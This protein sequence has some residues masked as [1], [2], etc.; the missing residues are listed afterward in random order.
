MVKNKAG[1]KE[2]EITEA[3]KFIKLMKKSAPSENQILR[4]FLD[5]KERILHE[6]L[7]NCCSDKFNDIKESA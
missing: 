6:D 7:F 4:E 3:L 5:E 2:M 1:L